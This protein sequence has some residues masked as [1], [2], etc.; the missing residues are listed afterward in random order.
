M[1]VTG[2]YFTIVRL[3]SATASSFNL[4]HW[5]S[6][7][8]QGT[9]TVSGLPSLVH[10]VTQPLSISSPNLWKPDHTHGVVGIARIHHTADPADPDDPD[11]RLSELSRKLFGEQ[12]GAIFVTRCVITDL[13]TMIQ[14]SQKAGNVPFILL[15]FWAGKREGLDHAKY[16]KQT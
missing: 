7:S 12:G 10:S 4:P 1:P 11:D 13:V 8:G 6:G 14:Q 3:R 5:C 15:I 9:V 16:T 2:R